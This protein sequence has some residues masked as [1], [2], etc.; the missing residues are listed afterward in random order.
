[1]LGGTPPSTTGRDAVH[2]IALVRDIVPAYLR[3]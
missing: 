1:V 2:D 3:R